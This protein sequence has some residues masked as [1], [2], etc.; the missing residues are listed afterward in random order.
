MPDAGSAPTTAVQTEQLSAFI[1]RVERLEEEKAEIAGQ[2]KAVYAE[3]EDAGLCPKTMKS[4]VAL[5]KRNAAD[6]QADLFM[7]DIYVDALGMRAGPIQA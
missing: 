4:M 1:E 6:R 7:F 3:A 5:R 2:V